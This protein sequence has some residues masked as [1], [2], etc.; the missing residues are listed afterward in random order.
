M[1]KIYYLASFLAMSGVSFAQYAE[2]MLASKTISINT[3]VHSSASFDRAPGDIIGTT[4]NFTNTADWVIDNTAT[5]PGGWV[6][7]T[8]APDGPF[9]GGMGSIAS[10]SGGNF[11][12]FDA[13]GTTGE[14]TIRM[15]NSID[16]TAYSN[17]AFEFESYYRNF[18]GDAFVDI[19]TNGTSWTSYPVHAL[20][21]LNESTANP[22]VVSI[23]ITAVAANQGTVWARFRY[24]SSDDYAWMVDDARFVEGFS[25]NLIMN[26]TFLSAGVEALDYYMIPVSQIQP[27][28]FGAW[29][30]NNGTNDQNSTVLTV[31]AN[32]GT[33]DVYTQ[34]S[35]GVTVP[36]FSMD[37]LDISTAWTPVAGT[38]DL[39][40]STSSASTEQSPA[41]N[42]M[43][44]EPIFVGGNIYA[45][46]NGI[47][48]GSVGYLGS[49]PV[50]T[51]MGNYFE[52]AGN[53]TLGKI[54][55]GIGSSSTTGEPIYAEVRFWDGTDFVYVDATSDHEITSGDLGNIVTLTLPSVINCTAGQVY[56]IGAAH[57]GGDARFQTAQVA[58][59]AV[60][61][62]DGAPSQQNS[63]FIIRA[64]E[65]YLGLDESAKA[66]SF[67]AY[68]N[69]AQTNV[70]FNYTLSNTAAVSLTITDLT[71]KVV[72]VEDFGTQ[73]E[74]NYS[75]M[76][77]VSDFANGVYF[78]T[79][80]VNGV[81][82]TEKLTIST[83]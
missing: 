76:V 12:M 70:T 63:V 38:F 48:T 9:S 46:D 21:P 2:P 32:D 17:V 45:R 8:L 73:H 54:Q 78:Y 42:D 29:V 40:F 60:I 34:S 69:P 11:A 65:V 80:S 66:T 28:T 26:Q 58:E 5:T 25:D 16:L 19:S 75:T 47:E 59:G 83:N 14:A 33:S 52:F 68:P 4:M 41:D 13:D 23:N 43:V 1:K 31:T 61:Y 51:S 3:G 44:L 30:S 81:T 6:I 53:F 22:E 39:T 50:P 55:V 7:G 71:G 35:T 10:T 64:E 79:L 15:A 62:N 49:T 74:G 27:F 18:L 82:T 72:S 77:N 36:A 37:S 20:L 24:I 67:V 56:Y 57:Y